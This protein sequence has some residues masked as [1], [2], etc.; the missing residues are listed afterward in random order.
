MSSTSRASRRDR[1]FVPSN[2][3]FRDGD[4]IL[5]KY[6]VVERDISLLNLTRFYEIE[7]SRHALPG[8]CAQSQISN[9]KL[10]PSAI[11]S[12]KKWTS[13]FS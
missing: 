1:E 12:I 9:A 4:E 10:T 5:K 13:G 6:L 8:K 11:N 7:I 3:E 2:L